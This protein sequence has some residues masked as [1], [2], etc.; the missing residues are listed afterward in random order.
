MRQLALEE[1]D[2][3]TLAT[4]SRRVDERRRDLA[5]AETVMW[6]YRCTAEGVDWMRG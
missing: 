5:V 4:V 3:E 2:P 6:P 1:D